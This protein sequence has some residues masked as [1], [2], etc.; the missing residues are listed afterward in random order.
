LRRLLLVAVIVTC[1]G[2]LTGDVP[3]WKEI[4]PLVVSTTTW[5]GTVTDRSLLVRLKPAEPPGDVFV[6]AMFPV[7]VAP[8]ITCEGDTDK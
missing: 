2:W 4:W 3:T 6:S 1:V 8:P 7:A 5:E